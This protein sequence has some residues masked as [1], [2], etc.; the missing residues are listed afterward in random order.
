[1]K[2]AKNTT[3]KMKIEYNIKEENILKYQLFIASKSKQ[4]I[5]QRNILKWAF[6]FIWLILS[7]YFIIVKDNIVV[8]II[9]LILASFWLFFVTKTLAKKQKNKYRNF[10]K[11]Q[12]GNQF[13]KNQIL[14]LNENYVSVED[15]F[16][17]EKLKIEAIET[18][19]DLNDIFLIDTKIGKGVIIPKEAVKNINEF[20]KYFE[21][22]KVSFSDETNWIWK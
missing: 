16:G 3:V 9:F 11:E 13:E 12:F 15:E 10:V 18:L 2:L 21:E 20:K 1:M 8:S 22:R 7:V 14:S 6:P 4:F 19:I 17:E 5:K